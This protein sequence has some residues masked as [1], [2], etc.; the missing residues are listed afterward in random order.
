MNTQKVFPSTNR[1]TEFDLIQEEL[2]DL[3]LIPM[4]TLK[5]EQRRVELKEKLRNL[6]K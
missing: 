2:A 1:A 6:Q 4:D 3:D 5:R